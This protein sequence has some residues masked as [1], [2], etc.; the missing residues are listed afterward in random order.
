MRDYSDKRVSDDESDETTE[1]F[2]ESVYF[3]TLHPGSYS[4]IVKLWQAVKADNPHN[5]HYKDV[6]EWLE[7]QESYSRHKQVKERFPRQKNL[8]S[9]VDEQWDADL[10]DMSKFSRKNR[11]YKFLAVFIDIF[12]R[13]LWVEPMKSKTPVEM[14]L[15]LK[16]VFALGRKPEFMRTDRG[17]E[18]MGMP[19]QQYLDMK[20]V[21]HFVAFNVNHANYAERVIRTLKGKIYRYF[22]KNQTTVYI[23]HLD[24]F[25]DSY[26]DTVHRGTGRR[27]IDI[28]KANEQEVYEKLYLPQQLADDKQV[29]DYKFNVGD[30]VHIAAARTKFTKG[31]VPTFKKEV[32]KVKYRTRTIP[33]RYKL[34]DLKRRDVAGTVY[35]AEIQKV[36]YDKG[37]YRLEKVLRRRT[38][39]KEREALVK[40]QGYGEDFNSWIPDEDVE[41]YRR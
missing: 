21:H 31:Y 30:K 38:R 16:R 11:G 10:M 17:G 34:V 28:T 25:V 12:S 23:D 19:V 8:M 27:P 24:D 5:L 40:W 29:I 1:Q 41:K 35:E 7:K 36:K 14:V 33:P 9:H 39:D 22:M 32:F 4:G 26:L 3:D 20:R 15:V 18:Y 37:L 13:Y 6:K 2:L